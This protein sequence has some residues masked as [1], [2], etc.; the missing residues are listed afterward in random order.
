M[1]GGMARILGCQAKEIPLKSAALLCETVMQTALIFTLRGNGR[2]G[3]RTHVLIVLSFRWLELTLDQLAG[4]LSMKAK[5]LSQV[6]N[7]VLGQNFFDFINR[8]RIQEARRLLTNP[9]DPKVTVLEILYEVG[10]NSKSSFNTLFK[11]YTGLTPTEFRRR[12]AG[13]V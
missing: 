13:T 10:F 6:I 11:K 9:V 8:Y 1:C 7:E 4:Q 3:I 12:Y 2:G 5:L